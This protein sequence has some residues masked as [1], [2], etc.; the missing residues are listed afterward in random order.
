MLHYL[1]CRQREIHTEMARTVNT[2]CKR[3]FTQFNRF[4]LLLIFG[5]VFSFFHPRSH[6]ST[7]SF[8]HYNLSDSSCLPRFPSI[9]QIVKSSFDYISINFFLSTMLF[10]PVCSGY[11]SFSKRRT[12]LIT[13]RSYCGCMDRMKEDELDFEVKSIGIYFDRR[14]TDELVLLYYAI[15]FQFS[16]K[17][18]IHERKLKYYYGYFYISYY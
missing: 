14:E 4:F 10:S 6:Y 11:S 15:E 5:F 17:F 13:K 8:P 2:L 18:S 12:R 16:E 9:F 7:I 1:Q 3:S